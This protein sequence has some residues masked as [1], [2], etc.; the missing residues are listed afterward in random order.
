[1]LLALMDIHKNIQLYTA[2]FY[3][4]GVIVICSSAFLKLIQPIRQVLDLPGLTERT[5]L[6]L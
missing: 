1:M 6:H 4:I 3:Q 2:P 5:Y